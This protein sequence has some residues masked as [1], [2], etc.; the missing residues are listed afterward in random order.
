MVAVHWFC[1]NLFIYACILAFTSFSVFSNAAGFWFLG[2]RPCNIVFLI[3][4]ISEL[5]IWGQN[6]AFNVGQSIC[7]SCPARASTLFTKL[8]F[9]LAV[10]LKIAPIQVSPTLLVWKLPAKSLLSSRLS[11]VVCAKLS[12]CVRVSLARVPLPH[13]ALSP[14]NTS[15]KRACESLLVP[16]I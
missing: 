10:R 9:S 11:I 6:I 8:T 3:I 12:D 5:E 13:C 1:G 2:S 15:C 14:C 4:S 16:S 7:I